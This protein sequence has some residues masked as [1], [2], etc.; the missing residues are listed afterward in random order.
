MQNRVLL[1]DTNLLCVSINL[2]ASEDLLAQISLTLSNPVITFYSKVVS[3]HEIVK[4]WANQTGTAA[5][6]PALTIF[7]YKTHQTVSEHTVSGTSEAETKTPTSQKTSPESQSVYRLYKADKLTVIQSRNFL[8][9][10]K[11][12]IPTCILLNIKNPLIWHVKLRWKCAE[13]SD[14]PGWMFCTWKQCI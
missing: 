11:M 13:V 5:F 14:S 2:S 9:K 10:K 4:K 6:E 3:R 1:T 7:M 12:L 8:K